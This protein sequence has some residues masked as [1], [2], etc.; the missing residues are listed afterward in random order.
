[1]ASLYVILA[2]LSSAPMNQLTFLNPFSVFQNKFSKSLPVSLKMAVSTHFFVILFVLPN[3]PFL[4]PHR[5][6]WENQ[7]AS[8]LF[9]VNDE[10]STNALS[11]LNGLGSD[12]YHPSSF[13]FIGWASHLLLDSIF[14]VDLVSTKTLTDL[15]SSSTLQIDMFSQRATI[16]MTKY[17]T[18]ILSA[19]CKQT[20]VSQF[21][22]ISFD[23]I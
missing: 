4:P 15:F 1:M 19:S 21:F 9:S 10:M 14:P 12:N 17:G 16:T 22:N 18:F 20:S 5:T 8:T 6:Q 23:A 11:V 13:V 7:E 2:L 3:C